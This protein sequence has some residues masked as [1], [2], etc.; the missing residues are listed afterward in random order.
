M[1]SAQV[2]GWTDQDAARAGIIHLHSHRYD[3]VMKFFLSK[4][5]RMSYRMDRRGQERR[6]Q[7]SRDRTGDERTGQDRTVEDRTGNER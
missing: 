3:R 2:S 7:E 4:E 5:L 6:G 1:N